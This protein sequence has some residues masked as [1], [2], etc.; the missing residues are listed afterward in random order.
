[1]DDEIPLE[2]LAQ[3]VGA[4]DAFQNASKGIQLYFYA[5]YKSNH[6]GRAPQLNIFQ[7]CIL[8]LS[9]PIEYAKWSAW[10]IA[11]SRYRS[12]ESCRL[13]YCEMARA[14]GAFPPGEQLSVMK[15]LG[16]KSAGRASSLARGVDTSE[17]GNEFDQLINACEADD[18]GAI[19]FYA[20]CHGDLN[21]K[22]EQGTTLLQFAADFRA[23]RVLE[24]LLAMPS[25]QVDAQDD[26]GQTALHLAAINGAEWRK[27]GRMLIREGKA[28]MH[29]QDYEGQTPHQILEEAGIDPAS[30]Q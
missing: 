23:T 7:R 12:S 15:V 11:S 10:D 8:Y 6:N 5:L 22:T 28:N 1:M 3:Y 9:N 21:A 18:A 25:V 4:T 16:T 13:R 26:Q 20:S 24:T 17:S 29:I 27:V 2:A 19:R 14:I 30:W